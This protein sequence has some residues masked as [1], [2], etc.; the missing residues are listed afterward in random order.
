ME[1]KNYAISVRMPDQTSLE[2]EAAQKLLLKKLT[3]DFKD[4]LADY[5]VDQSCFEAAHSLRCS[6]DKN[7]VIL[8]AEEPVLGIIQRGQFLQMKKI[9]AM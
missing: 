6:D 7:E 4:A 1:R 3:N 8:T 2:T 5:L 9:A